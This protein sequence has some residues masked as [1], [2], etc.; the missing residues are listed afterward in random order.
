MS[1]PEGSLEAVEFSPELLAENLRIATAFARHPDL[2]FRGVLFSGPSGLT[3]SLEGGCDPS[4]RAML[5]RLYDLS[6]ADVEAAVITESLQDSDYSRHTRIPAGHGFAFLELEDGQLQPDGQRKLG[7][8][9]VFVIA[10]GITL[11]S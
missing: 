7:I 8:F 10:D 4:N 9:R 5:D 2:G 1:N 6:H 3:D 11:E